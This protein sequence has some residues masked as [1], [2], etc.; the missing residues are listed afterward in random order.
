MVGLAACLVPNPYFDEVEVSSGVGTNSSDGASSPG[1][2][3]TES[4]GSDSASSGS[5][6]SGAGTS[7]SADPDL[8]PLRVELP[9][10]G[11]GSCPEGSFQTDE[12][13]LATETFVG[14]PDTEYEAIVHVRG[15]VSFKEYGGGTQ[16]GRWNEGET[17][18]PD[19]RNQASLLIGDP[20][21]TYHLP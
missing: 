12:S 11:L 18:A 6:T 1:P 9:C 5:E 15:V 14:A 17:P 10:I 3:D 8:P 2:D 19:T 21:R 16:D 20:P 7:G 13:I 4:A